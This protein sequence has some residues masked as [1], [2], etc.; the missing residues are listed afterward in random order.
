M[1]G[2]MGSNSHQIARRQLLI[3]L[4]MTHGGQST[5][6][7]ALVKVGDSKNVDEATKQGTC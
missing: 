6:L 4:F 3:Y 2:P 1:I 7:W 5:H